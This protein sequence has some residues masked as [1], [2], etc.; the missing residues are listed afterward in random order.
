MSFG[1]HLSKSS[2]NSSELRCEE[3][4]YA[5]LGLCSTEPH[6]PSS[7]E[8]RGEQGTGSVGTADTLTAGDLGNKTHIRKCVYMSKMFLIG[9][10]I[11]LEQKC[12]HEP[13]KLDPIITNI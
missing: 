4:E 11:R 5:P 3:F 7:S 13:K 9:S 8:Q 10:K 6:T 2:E 1:S 12:A